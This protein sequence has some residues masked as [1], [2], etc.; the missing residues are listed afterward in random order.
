MTRRRI[1]VVDDDA[2]VARSLVRALREHEVVCTSDPASAVERALAFD[3]ELV[4]SDYFLGDFTGRDV[5]KALRDAD[6]RAPILLMSGELSSRD[7]AEWAA[8]LADDFLAKPFHAD[9]LLHKVQ[10]LLD[11]DAVA[12]ELAA[13]S[14]RDQREAEAAHELLSRMVGRGVYPA[15]VRIVS[16]PAGRFGGD[17]VLAT[18]VGDRYRLFVGD[19]TG[20]TLASAL[21]TIPL[22]MIFYGASRKGIGMSALLQTINEQLGELLPRSM[23]CAAAM[24]EIDRQ[25]GTLS[26]W[27]GGAPDLAILRASGELERVASA[28]PPLGVIRN[29]PLTPVVSELPI[30]PGDRVLA[31]TD[32]LYEVADASGQ[33]LGLEQVLAAA[34]AGAPDGAFDRMLASRNR[35][36]GA[37]KADDDLCLV[38]VAV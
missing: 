38:E 12:R 14:A 29:A 20:H 23:F 5:I 6:I 18:T 37:R 25:R 21:V 17:V 9:L 11:A 33:L 28:D 24:I 27:S 15:G 1:L 22:S 19:V 8:Y 32:G 13:A 26:A 34:A 31:F 2:F 16:T 4:I 10:R 3:P 30:A 7:W 35:H 36:Q